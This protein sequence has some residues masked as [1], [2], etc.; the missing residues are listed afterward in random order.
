M[1]RNVDVTGVPVTLNLWTLG[2]K[3]LQTQI[4]ECQ[5]KFHFYIPEVLKVALASSI[6]TRTA[7]SAEKQFLI[8]V[9]KVWN[10]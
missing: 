10:K 4:L 7:K 8:F 2:E 6:Q 9:F 1:H 3:G 5:E